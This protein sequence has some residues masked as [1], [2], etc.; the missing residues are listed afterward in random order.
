MIEQLVIRED[1]KE[2]VKENL[3]VQEVWEF[4]IS[5]KRIADTEEIL[6]KAKIVEV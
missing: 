2:I 5:S 4:K 1:L 3:A 6:K